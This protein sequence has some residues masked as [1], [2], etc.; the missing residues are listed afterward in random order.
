MATALLFPTEELSPAE[1]VARLTPEDR[2]AF[3]A[4]FTEDEYTGLWHDWQFWARPQQLPPPDDSWDIFLMCAGRGSGKTR[5]AAELIH[6]WAAEIPGGYFALIGE[7]AAEVRD[8]MLEGESGLIPTQ[9]PW[10]PCVY[11]PSKR[12]VVWQNGAWATCFSGDAPD[13]LRGPNCH[14]AWLDE[15]CKYKYSEATWNNL[16]LVLRAGDH[17]RAVV[18]TTP[19]PISIL[20]QLIADPQTCMRTWST[21]RNLANL[22]PT[23]IRRI[24]SRY[25]GTRLGRQELHAEILG[26]TPGALWNR[27]LLESTR[28]TAPP[29][30]RR[31]VVGVDPTA[32]VENEAGIVVAGLGQDGHGY[33]LE[34]MSC[35]GTPAQ[36]GAQV[37]TAYL[38]WRADRVIV[39]A[40]NGGD[41]CLATIQTAARAAHVEVA[42]KK[43]H[44]SKGK[45]ARAEPVSALYEQQRCHHVG[46][47]ATLED[48]QCSYTPAESTESPNHLDASVWAITELLLHPEKRAGVW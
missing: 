12:R 27:D 16:E 5:P 6:Q 20:K 30:L 23:F 17:P 32:S 26:D 41:M 22:A 28:V 39:E 9:K 29:P 25:E 2:A 4:D 3:F 42:L 7:T 35:V 44:A 33:I 46:M 45:Y 8:T 11:E 24:L 48:E 1:A 15:L 18:S 40:N 38:K 31:I 43:I 37:V 36:W 13:Q 14:G 34:D 19:R 47:F 21:Y 10:N